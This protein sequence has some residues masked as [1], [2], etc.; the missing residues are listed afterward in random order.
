MLG[1]ETLTLPIRSTIVQ[2]SVFLAA[3]SLSFFQGVLEKVLAVYT[4]SMALPR[5]N[6]APAAA[7]KVVSLKIF[8]AYF[9]RALARIQ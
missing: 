5:V 1:S 3:Q 2:L 7:R 4:Q 6:I 8:R 9:E